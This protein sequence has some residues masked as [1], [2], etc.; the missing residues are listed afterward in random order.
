MQDILPKLV[1]APSFAAVL[2]FVYGFILFTGILSFTG[3]KLLPDLTT[4]VGL[5]NY[6]R[7]FN[8]P[9]WWTSLKN[10]VASV[11]SR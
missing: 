9:N 8:H 1:L 10:A 7:L 6:M 5:G 4:W 3:S 11:F 2:L